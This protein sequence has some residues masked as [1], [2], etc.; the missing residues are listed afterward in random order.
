MSFQI[1]CPS[2]AVTRPLSI[3]V[4]PGHVSVDFHTARA[5]FTSVEEAVAHI[6]GL[7][8]ETVVVDSWYSGPH[9]RGAAFASASRSLRASCG[10]EGATR[11]E[12]RSWRGTLDG[13]EKVP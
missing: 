2:T 9:L 12:R 7:I 5:G 3:S 6:R 10:A 13:N 4:I 1:P 8:E 11:V